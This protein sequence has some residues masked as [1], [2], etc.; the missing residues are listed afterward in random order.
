MKP[1]THYALAIIG[2][3]SMATARAELA[4]NLGAV[5][6]YVFRGIPQHDFSVSGGLDYEQSGFY[7]GTWAADVGEGAEVDLYLGYGGDLGKVSYGIGATGY[8]YT[9]DFDDTYQ[10][11]N[12]SLGYG[13][14]T[15]DA[16][17][18]QYENFDGPTQDYTFL[19]LTLAAKGFFLTAGG[20]GRDFDG[21]YYEAGYGASIEGF[22][23]SFSWIYSN[24]DLLGGDD[25]NTLVLGVTK[26]FTL[27][28]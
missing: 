12:F 6:D 27:T 5:S 9:D 16:A 4:A 1:T 17:F 23:L 11:L 15:L 2:L 3:L 28:D 26:G 10:E 25:D 8:F 14:A 13:F 22:D 7:A 24:S 21:E 20:F 19:S 18:G